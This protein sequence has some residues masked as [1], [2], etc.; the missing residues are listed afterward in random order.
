MIIDQVLRVLSG[1]NS[2]A[3]W[4]GRFVVQGTVEVLS[5]VL[6]ETVAEE[7]QD[8]YDA[9]DQQY[10]NSHLHGAWGK[11]GRMRRQ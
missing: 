5:L 8:H 3:G 6:E 1:G 9:D 7:G 2:G 10:S 4:C 11:K